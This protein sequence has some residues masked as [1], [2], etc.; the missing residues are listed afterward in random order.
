MPDV[1]LKPRD[2]SS[3]TSDVQVSP[4][5]K[6]NH[7]VR[8][9]PRGAGWG[10][11]DVQVY[12]H[13]KLEAV[14]AEE[15]PPP[16]GADYTWYGEA[17]MI[18]V[19]T[20][21]EKPMTGGVKFA[22]GFGNPD[23]IYC[24]I[25]S[26]YDPADAV[27][28]WK[29]EITIP[30]LAVHEFD[31][32]A[33]WFD[34]LYIKVQAE[35]VVQ[36]NV[37]LGAWDFQCSRL[38]C[39]YNVNGGADVLLYDSGGPITLSGVDYDPREDVMRVSPVHW[40][41]TEDA[42]EEV[43]PDLPGDWAAYEY[44]VQGGWEFG[45]K[46][47][48]T[49]PEAAIVDLTPPGVSCDCDYDL[50][51]ITLPTPPTTWGVI[52]ASQMQDKVVRTDFGDWPY[53]CD[54]NNTALGTPGLVHIDKVDW[55]YHNQPTVLDMNAKDEGLVI[56]VRESGARCFVDA[57]DP[58][59]PYTITGPTEVTDPFTYM[60]YQKSVQNLVGYIHTEQH[61]ST[62]SCPPLSE[63]E[64]RDPG[65]FG[66]EGETFCYY[67]AYA[68]FLHQNPCDYPPPGGFITADVGL[69]KRRLVA[70]LNASR[71][72]MVRIEDH[73]LN[74][75]ETNDLGF[76]AEWLHIK[77]DKRTDPYQ[78]FLYYEVLGNCYCRKSDDGGRSFGLAVNLG[79]GVKPTAEIGVDGTRYVY[80]ITGSGP[81]SI[82]GKRFD[83]AGNLLES[84]FVAQ[85]G[86]DNDGIAATAFPIKGGENRVVLDY[87]V[88]GVLTTKTSK[89]GITFV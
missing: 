30:Q 57:Y 1:P 27:G 65:H 63:G 12:P 6:A 35:D 75:I 53:Y 25:V 50:A 13:T 89:D 16:S 19:R 33:P 61:L 71:S 34:A 85:S 49:E 80:R 73:A 7:Y 21:T 2:P 42:Q 23:A 81:Y 3:G 64:V 24:R 4:P 78:V 15:P 56:S 76:T 44:K 29:A 86:V 59:L 5:Q 40:I 72:V 77:I 74:T 36:T 11:H 52:I 48:T 54:R 51:S 55:N 20:A 22:L 10:D 9:R 68:D 67:Q 70:Y 31:E 79:A 43:F 66:P 47:D 69:D 87:M 62:E 37:C 17:S 84:E 14:A 38:R 41:G 26:V 82:T 18:S 88:A 83:R 58:E 45:W 39:Y 28:R 32:A 46:Y 60:A 8:V